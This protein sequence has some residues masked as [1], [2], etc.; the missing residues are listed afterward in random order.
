MEN[1]I[2]ILLFLTRPK[3]VRV[4]VDRQYPYGSVSWSEITMQQRKSS[5]RFHIL[6]TSEEKRFN[7]LT[8]Y[9]SSC[10]FILFMIWRFLLP[11]NNLP[12]VVSYYITWYRVCNEGQT[13]FFLEHAKNVLCIN[14]TG[15]G[16]ESIANN[17]NVCTTFVV[18]G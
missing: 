18:T 6:K 4:S 10:R 13:L 11:K 9:P 12:A 17:P 5:L 1:F 8:F 2:V 15:C 14:Y 7:Y 16:M 3:A